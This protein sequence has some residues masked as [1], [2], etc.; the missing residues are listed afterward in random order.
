MLQAWALVL[1]LP[2]CKE[3]IQRLVWYV[4]TRAVQIV[5]DEV[6]PAVIS[7]EPYVEVIY[8]TI[9]EPAAT[10]CAFEFVLVVC[11]HVGL[12]GNNYPQGR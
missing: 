1:W 8:R 12:L 11:L 10:V 2:I 9:H 4:H 5:D 7:A 6:W 3:A